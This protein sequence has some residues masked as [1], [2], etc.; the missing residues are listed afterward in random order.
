MGESKDD[1]SSVKICYKSNRVEVI[2]W[3]GDNIEKIKKFVE[4]YD[5][6]LPTAPSGYSF[7]KT[8]IIKMQ[9]CLGFMYMQVVRLG[10]FIIFGLDTENPANPFVVA[11]EMEFNKNILKLLKDRD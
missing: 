11:S 2:Q 10:D 9:G 3:T 8:L 5:V 6:D 1:Y 4:P 7:S